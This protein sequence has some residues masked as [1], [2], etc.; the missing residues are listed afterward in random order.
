ML[1]S[2]RTIKACPIWQSILQEFIYLHHM[3]PNL[4][5]QRTISIFINIDRIFYSDDTSQIYNHDF[6]IMSKSLSILHYLYWYCFQELPIF[7]IIY[8]YH[9]YFSIYHYTRVYAFSLW[10]INNFVSQLTQ[11]LDVASVSE[12][13]SISKEKC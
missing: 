5:T 2:K 8:H 9:H 3:P 6:P 10:T 13:S 7:C 11:S 4:V 1:V 12:E